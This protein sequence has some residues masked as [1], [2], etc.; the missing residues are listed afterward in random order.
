MPAP[1]VSLRDRKLLT[2]SETSEVLGLGEDA[3]REYL[4]H[5]DERLRLPAFRH[6]SRW[7]IP[8]HRLDGWADDLVDH[9]QRESNA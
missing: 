3:V 8:T 6:G 7:C 5:P 4:V 2:V 1:S 9:Y